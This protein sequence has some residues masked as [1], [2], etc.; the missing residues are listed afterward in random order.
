MEISF[1]NKTKRSCWFTLYVLWFIFPPIIFITDHLFVVHIHSAGRHAGGT[2]KLKNR[3]CSFQI[4]CNSLTQIQTV[5]EINVKS[6]SC[7][8]FPFNFEL[9][10]TSDKP[11]FH[12]CRAENKL[13]PFFLFLG[14]SS[15]KAVG[16]KLS[17]WMRKEIETGKNGQK[18]G[19]MGA[20]WTEEEGQKDECLIGR[21]RESLASIN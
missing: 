8:S 17:G 3:V 1:Q 21:E 5:E 9:G 13:H 15:E 12:C 6:Y 7:L 16:K 18:E 11:F 4:V 2:L 10:F 14:L 20:E 19:R